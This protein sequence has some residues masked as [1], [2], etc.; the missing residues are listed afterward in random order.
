MDLAC[1]RLMVVETT[2]KWQNFLIQQYL[3]LVIMASLYFSFLKKIYTKSCV[4]TCFV[5]CGWGWEDYGSISA[6]GSICYLKVLTSMAGYV[7]LIFFNH[8]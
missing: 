2:A 4:C 7:K 5:I 3:K 8:Y 6:G 1:V